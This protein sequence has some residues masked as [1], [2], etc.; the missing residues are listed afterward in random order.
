MLKANHKVQNLL[1]CVSL[2]SFIIISFSAFVDF[3]MTMNPDG[4][5]NHCPLNHNGSLCTM[6]FQEHINILQILFSATPQKP[7]VIILILLA[8]WLSIAVIISKNLIIKY[9]KLLFFNYKFYTKKFS[10]ISFIDPVKR[11]LY[12]GIIAPK[13]F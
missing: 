6:T 13:I 11:A 2:L 12:K 4:S 10:Y 3:G 1:L 9:S 8:L 5:M 7:V